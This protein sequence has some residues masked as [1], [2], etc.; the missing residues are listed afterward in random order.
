MEEDLFVVFVFS[1][2]LFSCDVIEETVPYFV[3]H[4]SN[5]YS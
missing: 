2:F 3:R 5:V 4:V 1:L